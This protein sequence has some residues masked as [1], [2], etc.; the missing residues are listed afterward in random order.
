MN[1]WN[2]IVYKAEVYKRVQVSDGKII[3]ARY[4]HVS[5]KKKYRRNPRILKTYIENWIND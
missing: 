1:V 5:Q 2:S 3:A 4:Q